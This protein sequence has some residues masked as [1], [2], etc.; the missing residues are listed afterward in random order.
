LAS[1]RGE[2]LTLTQEERDAFEAERARGG[3]NGKELPKSEKKSSKAKDKE[4]QVKED[5]SILDKLGDFFRP[6]NGE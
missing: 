2:S 3:P 1:I 4:E 6:K 5:S